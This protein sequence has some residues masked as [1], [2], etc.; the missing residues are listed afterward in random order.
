MYGI[1]QTPEHHPE[2]DTGS[3][4]EL[5]LEAAALL[6]N[7]PAV[8]FAALVHDLGKALTP[9]NELPQ[10]IDHEKAGLKPVGEV[11]ERFKVPA[12][13]RELALLVC[14]HHLSVHRAFE[15]AARSVIRLF[16]NAGLVERP[17]LVEPF[18]LAVEADKRG[19]AGRLNAA[20][21][22]GAYLREAFAVLAGM[23]MPRNAEQVSREW[24]VA[25]MQRVSAVEPIR[26]KHLL[27]KDALVQ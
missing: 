25:H 15:M 23:P 2:V 8:R 10:H 19:R 1:P 27:A 6:S 5:T 22:Q 21:P 16:D 7:D 26:R 11:C 13:W 24:Q 17:M 14:E 4:I 3:H 9:R 18:L 20:Y 12:D